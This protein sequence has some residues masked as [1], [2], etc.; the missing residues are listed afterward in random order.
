M[1]FSNENISWDVGN[2]LYKSGVRDTLK[3]MFYFQLLRYL[4]R[5]AFS[6][7]EFKNSLLDE[8]REYFNTTT[9]IRA[10]MEIADIFL[11]NGYIDEGMNMLATIRELETPGKTDE[12]TTIS[13]D[14]QNVHNHN[15]NDSVIK[16]SIRLIETQQSNDYSK[17][18]VFGNLLRLYPHKLDTIQHVLD[19]FDLD[20]AKFVYKYTVEKEQRQIIFGLK[21]IFSNLWH[22]I[23]RHK[24]SDELKRILIEQMGEMD[25][26]CSSGHLARLISVIQGFTDDEQLQI[27]VSTKERLTEI[28]K[29][30]LDILLE[31]APTDIIENM[32][33][34]DNQKFAR[35]ICDTFSIDEY[36]VADEDTNAVLDIIKRYTQND[37][38]V[39]VDNQLAYM[40]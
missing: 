36:V 31:T 35:W 34:T 6:I 11:L 14:S 16:A 19:R 21:I 28:V 29:H 7:P 3:Y 25:D 2:K 17:D 10:R 9:Y 39:I 23:D 27:T 33:D 8:F 20:M 4:L 32:I 15:I 18:I 37:N 26:Y 40:N 30:K 38:I 5:S 22:F 24:N 13:H 1:S 12:L